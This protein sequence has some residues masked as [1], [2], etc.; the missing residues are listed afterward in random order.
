MEL[1]LTLLV[2]VFAISLTVPVFAKEW[3]D[4]FDKEELNEE[5]FRITDRPEKQGTVTIEDGKL[6][7]N[8]PNGDFG[9]LIVDGRPLVLREAPKGD[10]SISALVNTEPPPPADNYWIGL[11]VVEEDGDDAILAN[12]WAVLTIGGSQ[13][14]QKA[15]I[16][17]MINGAWND[18]GHFDIPEWPTYLKLEKTGTQYTGYYKEKLN[19]QWMKVGAT[20]DHDGME[21]P[22]LVG[23]G[24]INNW[25]GGPNLTLIVEYFLLE[26]DKVIPMAVQPAGKLSSM[27][28]NIKK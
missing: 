28:G 4:E 16:G 5:W 26:G 24:F 6:L 27:W 21:E 8:E 20:W 3:L 14:E 12:N 15:L 9:H 1:K 17:S 2:V 23:L 7:I 18:K 10:F 13:G 11:F 19:D 25:G 22:E